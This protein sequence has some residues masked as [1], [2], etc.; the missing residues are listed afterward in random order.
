M[1][2]LTGKR[3]AG[4]CITKVDSMYRQKMDCG[5]KYSDNVTI[6]P[7]QDTLAFTAL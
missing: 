3:T 6:T 1:D 4:W 5:L 2:W 7:Q